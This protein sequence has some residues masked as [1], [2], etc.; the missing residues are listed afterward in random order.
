LGFETRTHPKPYPLGWIC[1]NNNLQVTKHCKIK[2]A[3]TSNYVDEL[4]LD[5]V[6]LD[7]CGIVMGIPYLY[8]RKSMFYREENKYCFKKYGKEYF[9]CAHR[10]KNDR[11][12][13]AT[14]KL[15]RMVNERKSLTLMSVVNQE[16]SD[17]KHEMILYVSNSCE[18]SPKVQHDIQLHTLISVPIQKGKHVLSFSF[19]YSV[20]LL[21]SGVWM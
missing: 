16:V 18:V 13:A 19:A 2:F 20:L 12:F 3:I 1:G 15:K 7:I 21:V 14:G 6:P 17:A 5:I 11:S 8:D 9:V 4:E 10:M